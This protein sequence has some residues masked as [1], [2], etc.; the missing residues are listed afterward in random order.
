V[1]I[2]FNN[3][4][5]ADFISTLKQRVNE[6]FETH[7]ISPFG[8]MQIYSKLII[9]MS[10]LAACYLLLISD[11]L[12]PV[13]LLGIWML[14]GFVIALIGFNIAHDAGHGSFSKYPLVNSILSYSFNLLGANQYMWKIMHNIVHHTFTN[15]PDHDE[16][17]E[18]VALLRLS[19]AKKMK[20]IHRY[21]HWYAIFIYSLASLSWVI[22]KD[23]DTFFRKKIGNYENKKH[24]WHE[25]IILFGSKAIYFFIFLVLPMLLLSVPFWHV[26]IGFLLLH[27]V[28]GLTLA[29]VFQLAHVV[30]NTSFPEPDKDGSMENSWAVH[31][32]RTT[33]SFARKNRIVTW[34]LG[35]LNF[36][37]E[38][39]LFPQICHV[40]YRKLSDI[41]KQ[42]AEE[43]N[44]RYI[45]YK[46]IW[47][48][49]RSHLRMLRKL[50]TQESL[51]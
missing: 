51:A 9:L 41:V 18:P 3:R 5:G 1:K 49:F 26:L 45:E 7:Q 34:L 29:V 20:F 50:G 48:S 12:V 8:N 38:H 40:H 39:H 2:K 15:I 31:Q 22:K 19:T 47:H 6:Y 14:L 35:G 36:Q 46:S 32:I 33:S 24:P 4:E 13:A 23:F 10:I 16:D 30:E 44:L 11:W 28:E 17:L 27:I 25:Y 43:F 42:T 37:V 21:Q